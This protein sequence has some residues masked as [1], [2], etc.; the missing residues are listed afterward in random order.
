MI[1][2]VVLLLVVL[3]MFSGLVSAGLC[4]GAGPFNVG[5]DDDETCIGV[6]CVPVAQGVD[7]CDENWDCPVLERCVGGRNCEPYGACEDVY[8]CLISG[9]NYYTCDEGSCEECDFTEDCPFGFSCDGGVCVESVGAPQNQRCAINADCLEGYFCDAGRCMEEDVPNRLPVVTEMTVNGGGMLEGAG[10]Y[11]GDAGDEVEFDMVAS[12]PDGDDLFYQ[13]NFGDGTGGHNSPVSS[14]TYSF[15]EAGFYNIFAGVTDE[16]GLIA[17]LSRRVIITEEGGVYSRCRVDAECNEGF[18]CRNGFCRENAVAGQV[19][20]ICSNRVDDNGDGL[21]DCADSD[22]REIFNGDYLCCMRDGDCNEL[23]VGGDDFSCLNNVCALEVS[24]EGMADREEF[25]IQNNYHTYKTVDGV[26]VCS[27]DEWGNRCSDGI[28]NDFDGFID[29]TDFD[30]R[31]RPVEDDEEPRGEFDF[32]M[33]DLGCADAVSI[34]TSRPFWAFFACMDSEMCE[35][36]Q[37]CMENDDGVGMCMI[38]E[39][40]RVGV[41]C[42][43]DDQCGDLICRRN[44][45]GGDDI[46]GGFSGDEC[47]RDAHCIDSLFCS[48][49]GVC[50]NPDLEPDVAECNVD[51]DCGRSQSCESKPFGAAK[52]CLNWLMHSCENDNDCIFNALCQDKGLGNKCY[53]IGDEACDDDSNCAIGYECVDE[54]VGPGVCAESPDVCDVIADCD[55]DQACESRP[56]GTPKRCLNFVTVPCDNDNDCVP[57]AVCLDKGAGKKCYGVGENVCGLDAHCAPSFECVDNDCVGG[58]L[59]SGDAQCP[60]DATCNMLTRQCVGRGVEDRD[61]DG[62]LDDVDN[63]PVHPN[64]PAD[65]QNQVDSDGDGM[66]DICDLFP[67]TPAVDEDNNGRLD[68][69]CQD[70]G[71]VYCSSEICINGEINRNLWDEERD[72]NCCWPVSNNRV[73]CGEA[74]LDPMLGQMIYYAESDC[75]DPDGDGHGTKIVDAFTDE[76]RQNRVDGYPHE[77]VPCTTIPR[78]Q[79]TDGEVP[80]GALASMLLLLTILISFYVVRVKFK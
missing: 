52:R 11:A 37:V 27:Y 44:F 14:Y 33:S 61:R 39:G 70:A 17:V 16:H 34:C 12:D 71:G 15:D 76:G 28:D 43:D 75:I 50:F 72:G 26:N 31:D 62:V 41:E 48:D 77:N 69:D 9:D 78:N 60:G 74:R 79:R 51:A 64:G 23:E 45:E 32:Q 24:R 49:E 47:R 42:N 36:D 54:G 66:G 40:G 38:R 29:V 3:L 10:T 18:D 80:F 53:G 8:D 7:E 55:P 67:N 5:C 13:W 59:C 57:G 20:E 25:C 46:C 19:L 63:C 1:K 65:P 6:V 68:Q 22:C 30:C 35:G 56:E 58:E 4:A 2:R 73:G 21:V